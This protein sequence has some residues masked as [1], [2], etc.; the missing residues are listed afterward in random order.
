MVEAADGPAALSVFEMGQF[1][2]VLMDIEM[3]GMD[4]FETARRM[5]EQDQRVPIV[6]LTAHAL[7]SYRLRCLEAGMNDCLAKPI[8]RERLVQRVQ[9]FAAAS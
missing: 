7:E 3:P 1:D 5:R 2:V 6:A 9:R 4:G 8:G